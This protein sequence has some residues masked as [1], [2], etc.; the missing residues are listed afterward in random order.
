MQ[1][2]LRR[3]DQLRGP[4]P[5]PLGVAD[6]HVAAGRQL[7]QHQPQVVDQHR[8]QRLHALD[9]LAVGDAVEHLG[10]LGVL[11][12]QLLRALAHRRGQQQLA[13]RRRPEPVVGRPERALVG[14]GEVADLLD[15]VAPELDPDRVLLGRR[16]DV[17]DAAADGELAPL[18]DQLDPRVADRDQPLDQVLEVDDV[19]DPGR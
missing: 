3:A 18:L 13:A 12:G 14:D 8:R 2:L 17:E 6:Q 5:H 16:E 10:Q 7:V 11:G 4:G 9:R 1:E 15:V 19:A